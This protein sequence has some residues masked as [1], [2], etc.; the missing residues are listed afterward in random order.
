M[1]DGPSPEW[2]AGLTPGQPVAAYHS[3]GW[4][5]DAITG[6]VVRLTKTQVVVAYDGDRE[7]KFWLDSGRQIGGERKLLP[8]E[9]PLV[10]T[11]M[12]R[13]EFA[14]AQSE[15]DRVFRAA[16]AGGVFPDR[17]TIVKALREALCVIDRSLAT[18]ATL[19]ALEGLPADGRPHD[20][21]P[22]GTPDA[23]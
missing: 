17:D 21:T 1:S 12:R 2:L 4:H 15:L 18:C 20:D 16:K 11:A 23:E 19:D 13:Q 7:R 3:S 6:M 8:L 9:H 14:E 10:T 22:G 5:A